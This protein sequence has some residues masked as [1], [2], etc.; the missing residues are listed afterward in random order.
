MQRRPVA[1]AGRR[2]RVGA[3]LEPREPRAL[4]GGDR[5]D[6]A[7]EDRRQPPRPRDVLAVGF[8]K[9]KRRV[10]HALDR[11]LQPEKQTV[12]ASGSDEFSHWW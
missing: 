4:L 8:D 12:Q 9:V 5:L 10:L 1:E 3:A 7:V 6:E 11:S 2:V